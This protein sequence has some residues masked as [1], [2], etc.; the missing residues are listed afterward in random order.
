MHAEIIKCT[1]VN[2]LVSDT[3]ICNIIFS[4]LLFVFPFLQYNCA[5]IFKRY[6]YD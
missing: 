2:Q 3:I 5:V 4:I 1:P 6:I